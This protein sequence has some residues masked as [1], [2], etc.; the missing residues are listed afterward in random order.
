MNTTACLLL[1][2]CLLTGCTSA[3][4]PWALCGVHR[5]KLICCYRT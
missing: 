1:Y 4:R 3:E 2:S 5:D